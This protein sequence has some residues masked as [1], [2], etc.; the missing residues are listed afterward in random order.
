MVRHT[1]TEIPVMKEVFIPTNFQ[2]LEACHLG[3]TGKH[4]GGP[5]GREEYGGQAPLLFLFLQGKQSKTCLRL[6][7]LNNFTSFRCAE[8]VPSCLV[9]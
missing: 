8:A 2:K 1:D 9:F 4:Q 5:G 7:S 6:A 3:H